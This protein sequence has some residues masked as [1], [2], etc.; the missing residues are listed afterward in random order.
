[1]RQSNSK[2]IRKQN[3]KSDMTWD[4]GREHGGKAGL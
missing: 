2:K 4:I 3:E 1:M